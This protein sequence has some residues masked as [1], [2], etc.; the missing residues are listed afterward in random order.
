MFRRKKDVEKELSDTTKEQGQGMFPLDI[1]LQALPPRG[2][3]YS[4]WLSD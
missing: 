2:T 1:I 4:K 3:D